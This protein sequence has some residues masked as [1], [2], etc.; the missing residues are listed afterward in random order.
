MV[1]SG[2]LAE[3]AALEIVVLDPLDVEEHDMGGLYDDLVESAVIG[4]GGALIP[5]FTGRLKIRQD[6]VQLR[7]LPF[8]DLLRRHR[9]SA[10]HH[11]D[12]L[13]PL[14]DLVG[15]PHGST[16]DV[17]VSGQLGIQ[18]LLPG[19]KEAGDDPIHTPSDK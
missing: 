13:L 7:Q 19:L 16:A 3:P 12:E 15:L 10:G 6:S 5:A 17:E 8:R 4:D 18:N 11:I 14:Q 1:N 2:H 9:C